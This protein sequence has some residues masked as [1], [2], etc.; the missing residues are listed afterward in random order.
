MGALGAYPNRYGR[1][2][3]PAAQRGVLIA[4]FRTNGVVEKVPEVG[5]ITALAGDRG[6]WFLL[7]MDGLYISNLLQDIKGEVTLDETLTGGES[8][9]GFI[10][11]DEKDRVL[12]QVGGVSYRLLEVLGLETSR[13]QQLKLSVTSEQIAAGQKIA[14]AGR[15]AAS[16]ETSELTIA[17]LATLPTDAVAADLPKD[18][19]LLAGVPEVLVKETGNASRWWRAALAHDGKDL[20]IVWQVADTSPWKNGSGSF[21]H[22]FIGG[23][24]VDVKLDV[25]GRGLLR[26]L[27]APIE[28]KNTVVYFQEKATVKVNPMTYVV[29]NNVGNATNL[30]VVKRLSA[31]TATS[32]TS[33]GGYSVTL[34]VPLAELGLDPSKVSSLKGVIGVIYSDR[35]GINR[36]ARLYWND[37]QTD[38]VSDVPSEARIDAARFGPIVIGK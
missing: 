16:A 34:R 11:R 27:A 23:D 6:E 30:D 14:A 26:I 22:A 36:V 29:Q 24:C 18:Q 33:L 7:T 35:T 2:D 31:A 21:A 9:G 38:M 28:D 5:A 12:V 3:A 10:W 1:H 25:P 15:A 4:P 8:F 19:P 37:K 20:A 32:K 17:K 13:K